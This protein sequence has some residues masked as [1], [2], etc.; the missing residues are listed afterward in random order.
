MEIARTQIRGG[1]MDGASAVVGANEE[2]IIGVRVLFEGRWL[3]RASVKY[4]DS[5][6]LAIG[7]RTVP[8]PSFAE[9]LDD[10]VRDIEERDALGL[11]PAQRRTDDSPAPR[12]IPER[13]RREVGEAAERAREA[14]RRSRS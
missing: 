2:G 8:R 9:S 1:P 6:W 10:A 13:S 5:G 14:I 11:N 3:W 12:R 7:C 4:G